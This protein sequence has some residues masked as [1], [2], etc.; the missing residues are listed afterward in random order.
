[1]NYLLFQLND[2]PVSIE[3]RSLKC[4]MRKKILEDKLKD[5]ELILVMLKQYDHIFIIDNVVN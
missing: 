2:L 5:L 3:Y 4:R 1:M